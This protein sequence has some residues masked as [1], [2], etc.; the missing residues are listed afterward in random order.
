MNDNW[1]NKQDRGLSF[2]LL[3]F[4]F[5]TTEWVTNNIRFICLFVCLLFFLF[6]LKFFFF[7]RREDLSLLF[8]LIQVQIIEIQLLLWSGHRTH[9][10][11][12]VAFL[13]FSKVTDCPQ[14]SQA[15]NWV[16]FLLAKLL[17]RIWTIQIVWIFVLA[18]TKI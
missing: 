9:W 16:I 18:G 12:L 4:V 1:Q 8:L 3:R 10:L 13:Y 17:I 14:H 2:V 11:I 6:T 5:Q 15:Y 7:S